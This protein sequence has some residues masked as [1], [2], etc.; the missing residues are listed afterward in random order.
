MVAM[1]IGDT[2]RGDFQRPRVRD[3][4]RRFE[5]PREFAELFIA[6]RR[7]AARSR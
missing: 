2:D 6:E 1:L 5:S 7:F 3:Q 4:E